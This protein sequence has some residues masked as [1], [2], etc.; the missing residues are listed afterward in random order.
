MASMRISEL[1]ERTG[2]PPSTL[3]FYEKNGLLPADR[4]ASGYRVYDDE[5]LGRLAFIKAAKLL[6]LSLGEVSDLLAVWSAGSCEGVRA[7]LRPRLVGKIAETERRRAELDDFAAALYRVLRLLDTT[8]GR[9]GPCD[10]ECGYEDPS[11][12][13]PARPA[14]RLPGRNQEPVISARARAAPVACSLSASDAAGRLSEWRTVLAGA[15]RRD[16]AGGVR[17]TVPGS[18]AGALAALAAAEQRCCPFFDF[19][20]EFGGQVVHL[21]ARVPAEASDVLA[22]LLR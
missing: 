13:P 18:R 1:A 12:W 19:V 22:T 8:P 15:E 14:G 7:D 2:V 10:S 21:E 16:V 4:T 20:L 17:L 6:G 3:R 9:P 5:A 11:R